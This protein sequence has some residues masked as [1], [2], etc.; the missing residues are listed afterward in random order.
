M[1]DE[2]KK[3]VEDNRDAVDI[4]EV[5]SQEIWSNIELRLDHQKRFMS[6]H[7]LK[8]AATLLILII[9]GIGWMVSNSQ[10]LPRQ[11]IEME[12]Y[13]N[14]MTSDKMAFIKRYHSEIDPA[15]FQDIETLDNAYLDL[16]K[17]LKDD[18]DNE[19]VINAMIE[20][21]RTKLQI[22]EQIL[23]ELQHEHKEEI[24]DEIA[25]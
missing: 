19:E 12:A 2:L 8:I 1:K 3:L 24:T 6:R 21:Y 9:A 25:V 15:I 22:L 17:D 20:T 13:Y 11:I 10:Q 14:T 16:K 23:N 5:N 7:W 18:I 4:Y